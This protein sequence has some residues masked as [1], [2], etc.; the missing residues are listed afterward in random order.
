[1]KERKEDDDDLG[2]LSDI[3]AQFTPQANSHVVTPLMPSIPVCLCTKDILGIAT[4]DIY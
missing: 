3:Y 4:R 2:V 1:M